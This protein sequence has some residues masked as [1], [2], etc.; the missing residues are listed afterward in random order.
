V[1]VRACV[2]A[3]VRPLVPLCVR[4][5][6]PVLFTV[7]FCETPI[8]GPSPDFCYCQTV[9]GLLMWG[10]LSDEKAGLSFTIAAGPRQQGHSRV[11]RV[12]WY[13]AL[14]LTRRQVSR[15]QLQLV[16]AIKG[17][18]GSCG[19]VDVGHPLWLEEGSVVYNCCWSSSARAFSCPSAAG[20]MTIFYCPRILTPPAWRARSRINVP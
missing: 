10:A 12:C 18:L 5:N 15:L 3:R 7:N 20:L 4:F 1:H 9:T 14:S 16:L 11:Q 17:I 2:C 6:F 13:E 8:W 19:F